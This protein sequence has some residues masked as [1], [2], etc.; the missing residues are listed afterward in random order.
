MIDHFGSLATRGNI[1]VTEAQW[2]DRMVIVHSSQ[3]RGSDSKSGKE[4]C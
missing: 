1:K 4:C 2:S 3:S